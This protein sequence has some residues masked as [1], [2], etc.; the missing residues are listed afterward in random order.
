MFPLLSVKELYETLPTGELRI[1]DATALLP[2]DTF[3]PYARFEQAHIPGSRY[4]DG[5][6]FSDP[7]STQPHTVPTPAR[8]GKLF[9]RL[10]VKIRIE[11]FF[12]IRATSP[13]PVGPGG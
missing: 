10:G 6:E 9:G 2:G 11:L 7:E 3:N 13:L 1:F 8:F 4:F 12:T 5:D